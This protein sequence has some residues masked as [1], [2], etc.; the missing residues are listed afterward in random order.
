MRTG[1]EGTWLH[2][3]HFAWAVRLTKGHLRSFGQCEVSDS[4]VLRW[5]RP[6]YVSGT[7]LGHQGT[8]TRP[9]SCLC[10]VVGLVGGHE[11]TYMQMSRV[12]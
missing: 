12:L 1:S 5:P 3:T 2:N 9:F 6:C 10:R 7:V 8:K 4:F 11:V